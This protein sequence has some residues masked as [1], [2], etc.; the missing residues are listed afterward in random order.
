MARQALSAVQR[1]HLDFHE[2]LDTQAAAAGEEDRILAYVQREQSI[3]N[4]ECRQL[5]QVDARR[6]KYLLD[7]LQESGLLAS[8]GSGRWR[9]YQLAG[10]A[11]ESSP[12]QD[13]GEQ[14]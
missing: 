14:I 12:L 13:P 6:A 10:Q 1:Q 8:Q 4:A 3:G 7:K 11:A 5:L 9:R 2:A